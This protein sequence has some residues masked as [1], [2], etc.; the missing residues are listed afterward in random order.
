MSPEVSFS[1]NAEASVNAKGDSLT[2]VS[3]HGPKPNI[4]DPSS[5]RSI[6]K[7]YH[8]ED[9]P[10]E[11]RLILK[12]DLSILTFACIGF[13]CLYIDRGMFTNAYISGAKED[14]KFFGN[15]FVQMNSIFLVGYAISIIPLT[16]LNTRLPP[17]HVI[18]ICMLLWGAFTCLCGRAESFGELAAY[19]FFVGLAEGEFST[20][21][22]QLHSQGQYRPDEIARRAGLFYLA[23][24]IG[25]FSTGFLAARIFANLDGALGRAGWRW[26]FLIAGIVTLPVAIFGYI[27]FPGT[28]DNPKK[29]LFTDTELALSKARMIAVGRRS[30]QSLS[31][32]RAS[33]KHFLGRW[34][35]W[36]L[37]TWSVI[38]QQGY[39]T[40]SQGAYTLWIKSQKRYT[41]VEVNNLTT[42]APCT[43]IL[44]V[45]TFA[46]LSD[47]YG[48]RATL[49]IFGFAHLIEFLGQLAFVAYDHT[50]VGYKW[51]GVAVSQVTN[52]TVPIMYSWANLICASDAEERAFVLSSMLAFAMAFN[53]WVPIVL[54]PTVEAPRFFKGYVEGLIAQPVA[55]ALAVLV[56]YLDRERRRARPGR[57]DNA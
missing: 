16:I 45:V 36:V 46:W 20:M 27:T 18:P 42:V 4:V 52:A 8:P 24:A 51:F 55:F 32:N 53:S 33:L 11:R 31:L 43:A 40:W 49:P 5:R 9:G 22:W 44:F 19:R 17:Q 39:L 25:T 34:H 56:Y 29:W 1:K 47:R 37:V 26:M 30:R 38:F 50:S 6:L 13:W 14:L 41:T 15:Q 3:V 28:P 23:A 48:H 10:E 12:L 57:A 7:W 21:H 35:F 54:L 2:E